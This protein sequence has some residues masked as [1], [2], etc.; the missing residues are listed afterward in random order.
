[1][2]WTEYW[3]FNSGCIEHSRSDRV[4][5]LKRLWWLAMEWQIPENLPGLEAGLHT[6]KHAR[7]YKH[8]KLDR[9]TCT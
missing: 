2:Q 7:P 4:Q 8:L 1:M 9:H 3:D 6:Y 5:V